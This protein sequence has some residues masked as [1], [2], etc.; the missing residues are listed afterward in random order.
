MFCS[1]SNSFVVVANNSD[2]PGCSAPCRCIS[3]SIVSGAMRVAYTK[4]GS[5]TTCLCQWQVESGLRW[6]RS[7]ESRMS[8]TTPTTSRHTRHHCRIW[9]LTN[10]L[11]YCLA[12]PRKSRAKVL[13]TM[14]TPALFCPSLSFQTL[15]RRRPNQRKIVRA[16]IRREIYRRRLS[17][18]L[19]FNLDRRLT[20][21]HQRSNTGQG[22]P[23][24]TGKTT[25]FLLHLL[26]VM[27]TCFATG[28][29]YWG[30]RY[31]KYY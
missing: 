5:G 26:V 6:R 12:V 17:Y 22:T 7:C 20:Q 31:G 16:H 27:E 15:S 13:L 11:S 9:W 10:M 18:D 24:H 3:P 4:G 8:P 1:L 25:N 28:K 29:L 21:S 30:G 14:A 2:S 19:I 23:F